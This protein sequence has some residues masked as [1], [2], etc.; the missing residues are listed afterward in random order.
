MPLFVCKGVIIASPSVIV[1]WLLRT[2]ICYLL[3]SVI[4]FFVSQPLYS[5]LVLCPVPFMDLFNPIL[6]QPSVQTFFPTFTLLAQLHQ[7]YCSLL[8][9]GRQWKGAVMLKVLYGTKVNKNMNTFH[10]SLVLTFSF[11]ISFHSLKL[12]FAEG[13]FRPGSV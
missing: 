12:F 13:R 10:E 8:K 4:M 7:Q 3:L 2:K 1:L 9:N 5:G 11:H 6:C